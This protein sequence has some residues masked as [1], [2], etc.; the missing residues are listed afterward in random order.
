MFCPVAGAS[1]ARAASVGLGAARLGFR[2]VGVLEAPGFGLPD[3]AVA[4]RVAGPVSADVVGGGTAASMDPVVGLGAAAPIDPV[5]GG[6]VAEGGDPVEWLGVAEPAEPG[7][8]MA[9]DATTLLWPGFRVHGA[10]PLSARL[11]V[12]FF[13]RRWRVRPPAVIRPLPG[14]LKACVVALPVAV[15]LNGPD[16]GTLVV[17]IRKGT[18]TSKSSCGAATWAFASTVPPRVFRPAVASHWVKLAPTV[19]TALTV[20]VLPGVPTATAFGMSAVIFAVNG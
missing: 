1:P 7:F 15:T 10:S 17:A 2:T 11:P 13:P 20:M 12:A 5:V 18:V 8:V 6:A 4:L 14:W 9:K 16:A 3:V 19:A